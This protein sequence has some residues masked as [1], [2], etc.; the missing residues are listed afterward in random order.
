VATLALTI[1][2]EAET[3]ETTRELLARA[4][5]AA[6]TVQKK[7]NIIDIVTSIMMYKFAILSQMEVREMLGLNLS[8]EPRAI[9]EAKEEGR[10][11]EA[12]ALVSRLLKR[13]LQQDLSDEVRSRLSA[14]ALVELED[15]SEALLDFTSLAD[16]EGWLANRE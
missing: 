9:R 11:E 10:E 1:V 7:Q 15:L 14:L 12:I 8:E 3:P 13:R 6:F 4:E 5:Q 16:L 2:N